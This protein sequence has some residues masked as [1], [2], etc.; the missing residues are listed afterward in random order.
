[1]KVSIHSQIIEATREI[2][3]RN[4][5]YPRLVGAGKM[6]QS[7]A[8]LLIQRMEA[9]RDTLAWVRDNEPDIRACIASRRAAT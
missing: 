3:Q 1:M 7:E 6:R 4:R 9:I 8:D 2:D 5:V